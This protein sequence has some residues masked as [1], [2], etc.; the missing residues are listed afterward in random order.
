LLEQ[1]YIRDTDT[2]VNKLVQE[3][4][5]QLGENIVVGRFTLYVLAQSE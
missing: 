3:G 4:V 1:P 2:T 5:A